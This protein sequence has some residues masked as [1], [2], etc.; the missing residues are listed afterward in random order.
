MEQYPIIAF[1]T[2]FG[3]KNP[4]VASMKAVVY[5][6]CPESKIVDISHSLTKWNIIE[7]SYVL[8][9]SFHYFPKN[10]IFTV[11]IDPGVGTSRRPLIIR[12][13]NYFFVGPDNGVLIRPATLD[14]ILE[15]HEIKNK[16]YMLQNI[17]Y[18]FHGRDIFAPVSAYIAC[19]TKLE[20]I[21]PLINDP[22]DTPVK[23]PLEKDTYVE[24]IV[25][26][27][28][29]FGN[30]ATNISASYIFE[31]GYT[32]GGK[33]LVEI[34]GKQYLIPFV[35]SFGHVQKGKLLLQENSCKKLEIAVNQGS[36]SNILNI[37]PGDKIKIYFS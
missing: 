5:S 2:D 4:Y 1:L 16:K 36:A 26:F 9:C 13:K 29:D 33:F 22:V 37:N 25:Y 3:L 17:S 7:A 24:G 11:V 32:F 12:T 35:K 30:I 21:G 10:T 14:K 31:K 6:I 18:T 28:D 27:I 8:E 19:G 23:S 34:K 15:I 20:E